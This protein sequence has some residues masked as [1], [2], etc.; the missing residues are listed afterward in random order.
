MKGLETKPLVLKCHAVY[1]ILLMHAP[2]ESLLDLFFPCCGV[3]AS[4]GPPF[5]SRSLG[6]MCLENRSSIVG[7]GQEENVMTT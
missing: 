7:P 4:A 2:R 6:T 3:L 1:A 5:L